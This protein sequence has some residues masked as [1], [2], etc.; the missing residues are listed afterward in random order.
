MPFFLSLQNQPKKQNQRNTHINKPH[1]TTKSE[2]IIYKQKPDQ[3]NIQTKPHETKK[4]ERER[5]I[6]I[7]GYL[8]TL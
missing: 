2:T 5:E 7:A 6:S 1:K 8:I 3:K 4:R